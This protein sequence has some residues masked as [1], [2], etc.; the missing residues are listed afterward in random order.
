VPRLS[1]R[2]AA[3]RLTDGAPRPTARRKVSVAR[4]GG[5]EIRPV[6]ELARS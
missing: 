5:I 4:L 1:I 3:E 2:A 6:Q